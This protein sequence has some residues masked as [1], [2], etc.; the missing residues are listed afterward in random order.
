MSTESIQQKSRKPRAK[1][2]VK[3]PLV[4]GEAIV[5]RV[6]AAAIEEL[7]TVGYGAFRME[8]VAA[9]AE[10]N[11]T[12]VYRRW[13]TRADLV[14]DAITANF[15][16]TFVL[17]RTG[18]LRSDLL[19]LAKGFVEHVR[20]PFGRSMI[21]MMAAEG[22][23]PE[24]AELSKSMRR[25]LEALPQTVIA[26]AVA[27]GE[28]AP[29]IDHQVV[30]NALIGALHHRIFMAHED[31]DEAFQ[32]RLVDLLLEGALLPAARKAAA[33]RAARLSRS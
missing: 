28:L 14:R 9:R 15:V 18:A 8:E 33:R 26:N 12:T 22:F 20:S 3:A 25:D 6:H 7:A 24:L 29:D 30:L 1:A 16:A 11:K 5:Q 21:R 4:R 27:R 13:P 32:A 19:V 2:P 17:P 23:D 31:A 10:V